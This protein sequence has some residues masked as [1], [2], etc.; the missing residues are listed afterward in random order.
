MGGHRT[1]AFRPRRCKCVV[2]AIQR[3]FSATIA[4]QCVVPYSGCDSLTYYRI[5]KGVLA[6]RTVHARI[7]T[8]MKLNANACSYTLVFDIVITIIEY[9]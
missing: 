4:F 6:F 2:Y 8:K 1:G 9:L 3:L 7:F 5:S